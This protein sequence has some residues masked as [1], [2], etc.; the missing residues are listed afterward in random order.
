MQSLTAYSNMA[1]RPHR[2]AYRSLCSVEPNVDLLVDIAVGK[3]VDRSVVTDRHTY[4][5]L[6]WWLECCLAHSIWAWGLRINTVPNQYDFILHNYNE[7]HNV[8]LECRQAARLKVRASQPVALLHICKA[9]NINP[10]V[11][12]LI[13]GSG[14]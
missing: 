1:T 5:T 11:K 14:M 12:L 10:P 4:W 9:W 2:P 3:S 7:K 13:R 6:R 8:S